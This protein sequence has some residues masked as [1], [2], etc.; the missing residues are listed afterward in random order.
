M[1]NENVQKVLEY[2]NSDE[3][4][5]KELLAMH[6][7]QAAAELTQKGVECTAD[8]LIQ[9]AEDIKKVMQESGELD[10]A[11]LEG[12]SGGSKFTFYLGVACGAAVTTAILCAPW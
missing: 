7:D 6:P 1:S 9:L 11:A 4:F 8:E 12:V 10:V 2:L 5:A 3:A